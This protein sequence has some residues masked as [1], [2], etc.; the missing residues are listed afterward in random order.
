VVKVQVLSGSALRTP[1]TISLPDFK[2]DRSG[3]NPSRFRMLR[4]RYREV[5]L[6]LNCSKFELEDAAP[7]ALLTPG[8]DQVKNA[9]V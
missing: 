2:L 7:V 1:P 5:F 4:N 3:D 9:V 6:A 8:V